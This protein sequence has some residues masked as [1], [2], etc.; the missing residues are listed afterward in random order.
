MKKNISIIL[1]V[2]SFMAVEAL[3]TGQLS[4]LQTPG[5]SHHKTVSVRSAA[6]ASETTRVN[7]V[8]RN[9]F[10]ATVGCLQVVAV[11]SWLS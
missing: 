8:G 6:V 5:L 9:L 11:H 1:L 3:N 4:R 10:L 2:D 7:T